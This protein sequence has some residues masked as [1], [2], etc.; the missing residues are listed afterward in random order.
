MKANYSSNSDAF[1]ITKV[2]N[3]N[4]YHF[5]ENCQIIYFANKNKI[6]LL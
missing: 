6:P 4:G 1:I 5:C 3:L 2:S